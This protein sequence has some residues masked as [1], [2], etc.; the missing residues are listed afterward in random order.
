MIN[1]KFDSYINT[2]AIKDNII[3]YLLYKFTFPISLTLCK[4]KISPNKISI[5]SL[6]FGLISCYFLVLN[7]IYL[8]IFTWT[9]SII[10]DFCDGTVSRIMNLK[11][12]LK[13]NIDHYFD[14]IKISFLLISLSFKYEDDKLISHLVQIII[15]LLLFIEVLNNDLLK[16]ELSNSNTL[17]RFSKVKMGMNSFLKNIYTIIFSFNAHTLFLFLLFCLNEEFSL[18]I[19]CYFIFLLLKNF[20]VNFYL[21]LTR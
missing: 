3:M 4:L 7:F 2:N 13:F 21:L 5:I 1:K 19:L 20:T 11:T 10:L 8:F 18:I 15:F 6:I 12:K 9:V 17:I 16:C 14:L